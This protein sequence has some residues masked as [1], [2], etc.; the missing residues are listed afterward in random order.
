MNVTT[1]SDKYQIVIPKQIREKLAIKQR[2]KLVSY[3]VG[4]HLVLSPQNDS[5]AEKLAG[6]GKKL[7]QNI[8]P[9]EYIRRERQ[10]WEKQ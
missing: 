7:W 6:L 10:Q 8:D 3:I 9:V 2:Q 5:Y 1:V 4:S